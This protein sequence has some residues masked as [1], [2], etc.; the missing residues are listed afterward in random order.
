MISAS[1]KN[2]ALPSE[3][4]FLLPGRLTVRISEF[5]SE[6]AGSIPAPVTLI[7]NST[8]EYR[9]FKAGVSGSNPDGSTD[10]WQTWCMRRTENP[11]KRFNSF[12]VHRVD[13]LSD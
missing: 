11:E 3:P 9:S 12:S 13:V 2:P 4:G 10:R 8:A 7:H 1:F 6:G 5:D